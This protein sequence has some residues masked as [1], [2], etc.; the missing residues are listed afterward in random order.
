[1]KA[2]KHMSRIIHSSTHK[3][4]RKKIQMSCRENQEGKTSLE[5]VKEQILIQPIRREMC[6]SVDPLHF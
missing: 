6:N 4:L 2:N 5:S 1:M 3:Q